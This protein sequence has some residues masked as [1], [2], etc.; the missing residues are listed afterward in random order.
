MSSFNPTLLKLIDETSQVL[1][2]VSSDLCLSPSSSSS[3]SVISSENPS[4]PLNAHQLGGLNIAVQQK[5]TLAKISQMREVV[6]DLRG[7]CTTDRATAQN[8]KKYLK[9]L[10]D[11][12]AAQ[13]NVTKL[14]GVVEQS[15]EVLRHEADQSLMQSLANVAKEL[16]LVAIFFFA[17]FCYLCMC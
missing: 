1:R 12:A 7:A 10:K 13:A 11:H 8:I 14:K 6:M 3:S 17:V 15:L 5:A 2:Q 4:S 16:E 9:Q